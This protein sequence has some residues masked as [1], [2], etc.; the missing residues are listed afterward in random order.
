MLDV[1]APSKPLRSY[2][3]EIFSRQS[4]LLFMEFYR[5]TEIYSY[6]IVEFTAVN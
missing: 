5:F 3:T 2:T 6:K 1:V 4:A